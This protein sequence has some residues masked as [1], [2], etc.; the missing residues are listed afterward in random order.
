VIPVHAVEVAHHLEDAVPQFSGVSVFEL[1]PVETAFFRPLGALA[2]LLTHEEQLLARM[3]PHVGEQGADSGG[4]RE[5]VARHP[6]PQRAL[7]VH[8]FVVADR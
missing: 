1:M 7:T 2:E 6:R 8:H 5:V 3:R 4:L